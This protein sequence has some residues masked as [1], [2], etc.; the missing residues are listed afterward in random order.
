M[1]SLEV[2][3]RTTWRAWLERH[4]ATATE[5]WVVYYKKGVQTPSVS[6]DEAVEEAL[7]FGW[8]DSTV[9]T[10]DQSRYVQRFT[11]RKARSRWSASNIER[12]A[13]LSEA[14]KMT[15]AGL[16]VFALHASQLVPPQPTT[17]P[18]DL[19]RVFKSHPRAWRQFNAFPPGYRR[20]TIGWVGSAKKDDT[21]RKRLQQ[22]IEHSDRNERI[23]F[24]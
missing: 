23:K 18:S 14:G 7:C 22:L 6:Y 12:V 1:K 16:A 4:G 2:P 5:V 9:R 15:S 19:E 10:L 13:R 20:T 21:R 3:D 17:L 24:M 8:I 11:P